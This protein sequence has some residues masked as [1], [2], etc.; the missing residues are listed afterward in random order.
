MP[1]KKQEHFRAGVFVLA[2][3]LAV[4]ATV[5]VIGAQRSLFARK[6]S[7]HVRFEDS[8]GLVVGAP[9]RLAG[10]D[11]GTVTEIDFPED[12]TDRDTVVTLA[13]ERR[14][15]NRVRRDSVAFIDSKGLLGDKLVNLTVGSPKEAQLVNGEFVKTRSSYSIEGL[16]RSLDD[17]LLSIGRAASQA[18]STVDSLGVPQLKGELQQ[19]LTSLSA[20][21]RTIETGPGLLHELI[22]EPRLTEDARTS[23]AELAAAT[24]ELKA[25]AKQA[26]KALA[27]VNS[28]EG[29]LG[30]LIHGEQGA[31]ALD[32]LHVAAQ[33]AAE[34]V[35]EVK[36]GQGLLHEVVYEQQSAQLLIDMALLAGRLDGI[37]MEVEQ[38]RG[39]VGGLLK[40]PT[41]YEDLK[42]VI[43]N[44]ERNNVFK[45]LIRMSIKEGEPRRV[46]KKG[47]Q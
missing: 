33:G 38:G 1:R 35:T 47:G 31:L 9:V 20:I 25:A 6:D 5:F 13:V 21:L 41:V 7:L 10:V 22:Y 17:T 27:K 2:G 40:D 23:M 15:M 19:S 14:F 29:T 46:S 12:V 34:I 3:L 36:E 4:G 39:T 18:G 42:S 44:I 24:R 45:Q 28:G 37:V 32:E 11:V 8:S 16:A 30:T 26:N 43:G